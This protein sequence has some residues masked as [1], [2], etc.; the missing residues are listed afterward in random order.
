M[1]LYTM[2]NRGQKLASYSHTLNFYSQSDEGV[3]L[4]YS[5]SSFKLVGVLAAGVESFY[6]HSTCYVTSGRV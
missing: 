1:L 4:L 2:N 5:A 6:W 3:A